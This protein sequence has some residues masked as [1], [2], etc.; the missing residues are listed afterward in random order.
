[1]AGDKTRKSDVPYPDKKRQDPGI[2]FRIIGESD[3]LSYLDHPGD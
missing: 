3:C 2:F 1:M